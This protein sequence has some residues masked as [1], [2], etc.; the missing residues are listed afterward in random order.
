VFP[1]DGRHLGFSNID[2]TTRIYAKNQH[3]GLRELLG[4]DAL[5]QEFAGG[6]LVISR[7][8]PIDY[9]RFH[10]ASDGRA[11]PGR[12]INGALFSVSPIA[13]RR[14]LDSFFQ[15]K[16]VVSVL[17]SDDAG[18]VVSNDSGATCVGTIVYTRDSGRVT[19]GDER[20]FFKFGGSCVM[21]LFARGRVQLDADLLAQ[22]AD[23]REL[24]ARMGDHMGAV[25]GR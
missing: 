6:S 4:D 20:G 21:T 7:L 11:A 12:L 2:A 18:R 3:L 13:L 17:E 8:C 16:R 25:V 22:S 15:N 9:H 24:Y 10:Y 19:R 23:G 1:A 14:S 5:A